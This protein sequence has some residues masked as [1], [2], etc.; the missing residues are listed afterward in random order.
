[1]PLWFEV[2]SL[3]VLTLILLADLLIVV[4]RPHIP[5][6]RE[7]S[8]WV[9]FYVALALLFAVSLVFVVPVTGTCDPRQDALEVT[10][11]TP[12]QALSE[13]IVNEMESGRGALLRAALS[14]VS[15]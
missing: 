4:R 7:A 15:Y 1:M 11:V 8:L 13:D 2:S 14:S 6:M 10:W 5:S 3:V 9:A 12:K